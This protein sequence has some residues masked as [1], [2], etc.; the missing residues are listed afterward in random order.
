M[1][2]KQNPKALNF[3]KVLLISGGLLGILLVVLS[4][5]T[6]FTM[7]GIYEEQELSRLDG[8]AKTLSI[9]IDG[10]AHQTIIMRYPKDSI[11]TN[12][13]DS[14]YYSIHQ[15][16]YAA[17]I[18][19]EMETSIYT[20]VYDSTVQ[21]FCFGVAS[22][23]APF[24]KHD[25]RDYPMELLE[26]YHQGGTLEPYADKHGMWLSA[27]QPIRNS[28]NEPV[29]ILQI[30]AP[31]DSFIMESKKKVIA[32]VLVV[33]L[34]VGGV[35]VLLM[36]VLR[37]LTRQQNRLNEERLAVNSLRKELVANVSHD[38]RTPLASIQGYL[39]TI[40]MKGDKLSSEART[41]Y[42]ERSLRNSDKLK[43]LIEEL[44]ELSKLESK[45]RKLN[46]EPTNIADLIL[47]IVGS[48]KIIAAN[49]GVHLE[50]KIEDN[51]NQVKA[52]V[53]LI[54]RVINNLLSNAI[55]FCKDGD[56]ITVEVHSC[57]F[58]KVHIYV[59][60]TGKGIAEADLPHIFTRYYKTQPE[61]RTGSG[62]GLAIVKHIL[63]LHESHYE[64]KSEE[65]VGTTFY[66]TLSCY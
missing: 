34:I 42:L 28:K 35:A 44:F 4:V 27:F 63:E 40:L 10:D 8:I 19:N 58:N 61:N 62:L 50:A 24:W 12:V 25:Y 37:Q 15:Q 46:I 32:N 59:K 2:S 60:D 52:D 47:D 66:F 30:D 22:S 23:D 29:G 13:Q 26:Q 3:N 53:A 38:L 45:E 48:S 51:L 9:Q 31:F 36:T 55:K 7:I 43:N 33:L 6:Y 18:S 17:M 64:V 11:E 49:K 16:L 5:N 20:M 54:D 56:Q 57:K 39:E 1:Q 14:I 65:G 21:K 41:N